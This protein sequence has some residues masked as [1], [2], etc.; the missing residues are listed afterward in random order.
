MHTP[1]LAAV[2]FCKTKTAEEIKRCH[3]TFISDHRQYLKDGKISTWMTDDGLNFH[4]RSLDQMCVELST[5][6]AFAIP[7]VKEKHGAAERRPRRVLRRRAVR[8]RRLLLLLAGGGRGG[9]AV[10][11]GLAETPGHVRADGTE[12][13]HAV[14]VHEHRRLDAERRAVGDALVRRIFQEQELVA[15]GQGHH[16]LRRR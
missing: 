3:D 2:Y 16:D 10:V 1:Y 9:R 11:P 4:S 7:H 8:R 14:E 6:R 13:F 5:R 15:D 12:R